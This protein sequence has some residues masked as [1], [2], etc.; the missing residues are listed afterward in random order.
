MPKITFFNLNIEKQKVIM[1]AAKEEFSKNLLENASI[2]QIIKNASIP[3]GSFYTYFEDITDIYLYM[4]EEHKIKVMEEFNFLIEKNKSD[5]KKTFINAFDGVIKSIN[6]KDNNLLFK[7]IFLNFHFSNST[8]FMNNKKI[9][10][11]KLKEIKN[12]FHKYNLNYEHIDDLIE[13]LIMITVHSIVAHIIHEVP[14][15]K[16]R[17]KYI[18]KINLIIN[19]QKGSK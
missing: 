8:F 5:I 9:K 2:N 14:Y 19:N 13:I 12:L 4:L 7:N 11:D 16:V 1:N 3:R 15:K 17:E 6:S 18:N 10:D